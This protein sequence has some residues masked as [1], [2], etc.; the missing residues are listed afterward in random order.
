MPVGTFE[1]VKPDLSYGVGTYHVVAI[2]DETT[3]LLERAREAREKVR[4]MQRWVGARR[5]YGVDKDRAEAFARRSHEVMGTPI[6]RTAT[7]V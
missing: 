4:E 3:E 6:T 7:P 2:N 5:W 1:I